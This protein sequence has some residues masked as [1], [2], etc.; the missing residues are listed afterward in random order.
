MSNDTIKEMAER[1]IKIDMEVEA[2]GQIAVDEAALIKS[3]EVLGQWIAGIQGVVVN[4]AM[5]RVTVIDKNGKASSIASPE[6]CF[7][8]SAAGISR[9]N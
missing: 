6:L 5:G 7:M 2:P 4:A 9:A 3:R 8:L 1:I